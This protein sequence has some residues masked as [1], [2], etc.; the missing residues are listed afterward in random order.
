MPVEPGDLLA[1]GEVV[2]A[3]RHVVAAGRDLVVAE[4]RQGAYGPT[5]F[6][7]TVG[8]DPVLHV[9]DVD[10]AVAGM[11]RG[12]DQQAGPGDRDGVDRRVLELDRRRL[13][14]PVRVAQYRLVGG[15]GHE[16]AVGGRGQ[17][18]DPAGVIFSVVFSLPAAMSQRT[19][20]SSAAMASMPE[21]AKATTRAFLTGHEISA[22]FGRLLVADGGR[23]D[24]RFLVASQ[25]ATQAA[26]AEIA[27]ACTGF[28]RPSSVAPVRPLA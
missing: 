22:R 13:L 24:Q 6:A 16:L 8:V 1:G 26:S 20:P 28:F 21:P 12:R 27:D 17:G 9:P 4:A 23:P 25:P 7:F 3:D 11:L 2:D 10:D 19:I 18:E 15:G 14:L 5:C